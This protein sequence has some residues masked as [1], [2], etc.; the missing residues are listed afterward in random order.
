M[1]IW[2]RQILVDD[3]QFHAKAKAKAKA[4][5]EDVFVVRV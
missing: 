4:K 3:V 1:E 2:L 5:E